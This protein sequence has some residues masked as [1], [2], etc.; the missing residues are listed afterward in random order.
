MNLNYV[1]V[2]VTLVVAFMLICSNN[3]QFIPDMFNKY[4][5]SNKQQ[6]LRCLSRGHRWL[7]NRC[8]RR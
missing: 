1:L 3:E 7:G 6:R 4:K 8:V 2:L 5:K